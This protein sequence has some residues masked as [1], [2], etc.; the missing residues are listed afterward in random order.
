MKIAQRFAGEAL[1]APVVEVLEDDV[2]LVVDESPVVADPPAPVVVPT[3]AGVVPVNAVTGKAY[4][5]ANVLRLWTAELE[6]GYG[7]GGWGGFKQWLS[8]GRVVRKGER[9]TGIVRIG[10]VKDADG[11][12]VGT[13][14]AGMGRVFH[15]DQTAKLVKEDGQ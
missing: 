15:F 6:H 10:V 13:R 4:G 9:A 5:G 11:V 2:E 7:P 14:P 12:V 8:V 1:V 3:D